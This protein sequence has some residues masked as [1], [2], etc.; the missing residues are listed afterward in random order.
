[1]PAGGT[2]AGRRAATFTCRV[3]SE[4]SREGERAATD[5]KKYKMLTSYIWG[6]AEGHGRSR[7]VPRVGMGR[8]E[9]GREAK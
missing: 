8:D 5:G 3:P 4:W 7:S 2:G 1:M 6:G 9:R